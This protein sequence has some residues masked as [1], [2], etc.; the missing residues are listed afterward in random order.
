MRSSERASSVF[1]VGAPRSGSSILYRTLLKH[2]SFSVEGDEALQLAESAV[3]EALGSAPRWKA[4]RP[5]RLW[6][7]FLRDEEGYG[8]FLDDVKAITAGSEAT[9]PEGKPPWAKDVL[10]VFVEHASEVRRC[11]RL[12]EKTPTHIDRAE[13]LLDSLPTARLLFV[14]RHPLETYTSYLRRAEVDQRATW[15]KLTIE[16]FAAVYRTH[17]RKAQHLAATHPDRFL[18]VGY[19]RLTHHPRRE[20]EGICEYLGETFSDDLLQEANPNL[21]RSTNDPHLFGP[22]TAKTKEWSDFVD[23]AV[24]R[25]VEAKTREAADSWGYGSLVAG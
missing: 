24:A 5:P 2:P 20:L 15:A 13:W 17:T 1:I 19:E 16:E 22:I 18:T 4:P 10:E 9:H 23:T 14:H 8:R 7:F 6:L 21:G 25:L 12:V 3:L 11:H